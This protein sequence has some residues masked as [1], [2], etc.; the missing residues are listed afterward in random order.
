MI[1]TIYIKLLCYYRYKSPTYILA[2]LC[3]RVHNNFIFVS[4]TEIH[5]CCKKKNPKTNISRKYSLLTV[6]TY[7]YMLCVY[8]C[9]HNKRC[10][11]TMQLHIASVISNFLEH[12]YMY[13]IHY[14]F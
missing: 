4:L 14:R 8:K 10:L 13:N 2:D 6:Y 1:V 9:T 11:N 7:M 5:V 3:A 12:R